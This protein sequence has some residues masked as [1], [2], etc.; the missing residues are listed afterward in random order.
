VADSAVGSLSERTEATT[1][2]MK[3]VLAFYTAINCALMIKRSTMWIFINQQ[4]TC[5]LVLQPT[6]ALFR[7]RSVLYKRSDSLE[8]QL[9]SNLKF[10]SVSVFQ[11]I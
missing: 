10:W 9:A 8:T 1:Y 4:I 7:K 6:K 11:V 3:S 5:V 2:R